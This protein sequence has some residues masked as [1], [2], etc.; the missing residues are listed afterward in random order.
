MLEMCAGRV[1]TRAETFLGLRHGPMACLAEG[2][3]L[4][5]AFLSSEPRR[6]AYEMDLLAETAPEGP[7]PAVRRLRAGVAER[8]RQ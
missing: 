7:G 5:V 6:R 2:R 8:G 3:T 1:V 4:V